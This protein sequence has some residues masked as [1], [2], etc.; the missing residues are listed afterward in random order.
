MF[1]AGVYPSGLKLAATWFLEERGFA[2]GMIVTAL[3]AGSGLPYLFNL[4]GIPDWRVLLNLSTVLAL[5]SG[6]L[7]WAFIEEGP[8]GAGVSRF[9][10]GKILQI[11][12]DK[13]LRLANLGYF[14]HMWE[15]Y[16]MWVWIPVFL[17]EAYLQSYPHSDPS[18]FSSIGTFLV[19]L[20]G[21]IATGIGGRISDSFGRTKFN[22]AML[23]VSGISSLTIGFFLDK[24]FMALAIALIWGI[25]VIPDSPQYSSMVSELA[26]K[27]YVGTALTLQTSIGFL[28][29]ILSIRVTPLFVGKVGWSYGFTL[30]A[31]GPLIGIISMLWLR[32]HPD[33]RKIARGMK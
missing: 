14:G 17:R 28:L 29:T 22:I 24:P 2:M 13:S 18:F 19:F 5:L 7:V 33:S 15:L 8:H 10:P 4:T 32:K 27:E 23:T 6:L 26:E 21:A 12:G 25:T 9:D 1:L 20:T 31:L 3:T 16:A 11:L 30:L